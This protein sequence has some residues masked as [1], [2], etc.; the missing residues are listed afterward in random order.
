MC[1]VFYHL[2]AHRL[3]TVI[4]YD[5]VIV[6]SEGCLV[7]TGRPADLLKDPAS[8]FHGLCQAVRDSLLPVARPSPLMPG[9]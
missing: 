7:E 9:W 3:R 4:G 2:I 6:M 8:R 5:K 1:G